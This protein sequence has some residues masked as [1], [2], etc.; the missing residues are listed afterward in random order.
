MVVSSRPG[1]P[2]RRGRVN[3]YHLVYSDGDD[4]DV[5]A[6]DLLALPLAQPASLVGRRVAK[7]FPGHGRHEGEI[8]EW[9]S[10]CDAGVGYTVAYDDGDAE[11]QLPL[12]EVLR[13]LLPAP[14]A[15]A[16]VKATGG[17]GRGGSGG[18][19]GGGHKQI[20]GANEGAAGHAGDAE[21]GDGHTGGP[22]RRKL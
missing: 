1:W 9:V 15:A 14:P 4:E 6:E 13:L 2:W 8:R 18:A 20:G 22:K 7:H 10:D 17:G 21:G 12:A 5:G 19:R 16:A 3:G 11:S